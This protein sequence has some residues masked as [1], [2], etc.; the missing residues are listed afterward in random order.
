MKSTSS[1]D[2]HSSVLGTN[3]L[4]T[5]GEKGG[6]KLDISR[7]KDLESAGEKVRRKKRNAQTKTKS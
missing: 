1:T 3:L 4:Q 5:I 7:W 6:E 2:V